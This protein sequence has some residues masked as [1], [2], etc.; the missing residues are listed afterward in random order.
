MAAFGRKSAAARFRRGSFA[1]APPGPAKAGQNEGKE[2]CKGH[3]FT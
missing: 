2:A 1:P 3:L